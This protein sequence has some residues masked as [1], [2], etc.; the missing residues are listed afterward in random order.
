MNEIT[1]FDSKQLISESAR[2][3]NLLIAILKEKNPRIACLL[4][5]P[6]NADYKDNPS[7]IHL[8]DSKFCEDLIQASSIYF[9]LLNIAEEFSLAQKR[10]EKEESYSKT[11]KK[12]LPF[13]SFSSVVKKLMDEGAEADQIQRF[14]EKFEIQPVLTAHP[15]ESKRVTI[16]EIHKRIYADLTHLHE[17]KLITF[18]TSEVEERIRANIEILWQTGDIFLEK[19]RP[20]DEVENGLFY[21]KETFYP[22]APAVLDRLY[23]TLKSFFPEL[24]FQVPAVL[25]F[26]SWR[27]GDRDGNPY[28]TAEVTRHTFLRHA[29]F[30]L[31]LYLA[32]IDELIKILSQSLAET[33]ISAEFR[34]SLERD[35]L[36]VPEYENLQAR[37]PKEPYRLK[38]TTIKARINARRHCLTKLIPRDQWPSHAY[39]EIGQLVKDIAVIRRSLE[40]NGGESAAQTYLRPFELRVKTFGFHLA[41]LDIRESSEILESVVDEIS[42]RQSKDLYKNFDFEK[43]KSW[44]LRQIQTPASNKDENNY[45]PLVG[46]V[47]ST[48]RVV[49]WARSELDREINGSYI[50]S[51]T[52]DASDILAVYCLFRKTGLWEKDGCPISIV[53]LFETIEDLEKAPSILEELFSI[54]VVR[55]SLALRG[56]L[57]QVMVGYSDSNKDGS[58]VAANW[59]L[60]KAQI[61]MTRVADKHGVILK[62]F[63]GMGGSLSRGGGPIHSMILALPPNTLRGRIKITEQGE[64]ISAK[65]ANRETALFNLTVL[66]GGVMAATLENEI[67]SFS[68]P[69]EFMNEMQLLADD[70]YRAYR[71]L[72]EDPDFV[73]YF[74]F[75]S[76][77]DFIGK[78]NIGSRPAKRKETKGIQDLRAIPWVFSW[79][80]NRHLI[81]G[82][83]GAGNAFESVVQDTRRLGTLRRMY[84]DW[85]FFKN[86]IMAMKV[87]LLMA[88]MMIA[89][90]YSELCR[91]LTTGTR[92]YGLIKEEYDK[93]VS[94]VLLITNTQTLEE[95]HPH[96]AFTNTLRYPLLRRMNSL[97]AELLQRFHSGK[98][99]DA[100]H[101][102]LLLTMNCI[103]SGLRNTG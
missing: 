18:E 7:E 74:R 56:M 12:T 24:K 48:F 14:L 19:P 60:Q 90:K 69:K 37:N 52:R 21:F 81:S 54:D 50:V 45:S 13:W 99:S 72:V 51:M 27:G 23:R 6:G 4:P 68:V 53:P 95:E 58:F 5:V 40:Q 57:Q 67:H 77:V 64:T 22:V 66:A 47:L 15:T 100:D 36:D 84:A 94:S 29:L 1:D 79:T 38:L 92:I 16:L 43:R 93:V 3:V 26:S 83:F 96:L 75:A 63:H 44:L 46:E 101:T 30:V 10:K 49:G 98:A 59:A 34:T 8:S 11:P 65:Y 71:V 55:R 91:D 33:T 17:K 87:S 80:Q 20:Q 41:K 31:E 89:K 82:W 103:A 97:Q 85:P 42:R 62:F 35:R 25:Q 70:S 88:D 86:L 61:E 9:H 73:T 28:V 78:L 2:L 76:P 39:Q 32:E 102:N